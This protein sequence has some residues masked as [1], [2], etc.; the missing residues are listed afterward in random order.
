ML[1]HVT[2]VHNGSRIDGD[3][4]FVDLLNDAFF[5]NQERGAVSKALLLVIDTIRF[6]YRAFE[7][8]EKRKR[9]FNLLCEFAVGGDAV[10]THPK[11]LSVG[12]FE[13]CDISL[14]RF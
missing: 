13:F 9:D 6:D 11:N 1:E 12:G 10:Y 5:I 3:V 7:I 14:I 2:C 8:A 4:S